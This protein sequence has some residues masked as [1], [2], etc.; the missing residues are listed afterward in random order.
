MLMYRLNYSL[1]LL[2]IDADGLK[3]LTG[4]AIRADERFVIRPGQRRVFVVEPAAQRTDDR[5]C[6]VILH[7]H[8]SPCI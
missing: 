2:R 8:T 3:R 4:S 6:D 5:P 1:L 7:F